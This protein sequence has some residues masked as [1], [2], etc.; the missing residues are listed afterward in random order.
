MRFVMRVF[1]LDC[2]MGA[3][4]PRADRMSRPQL[5]SRVV[6]SLLRNDSHPIDGKSEARLQVQLVRASAEFAIP[7]FLVW[8]KGQP[9]TPKTQKAKVAHSGATAGKLST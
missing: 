6:L 1:F 4:P 2:Y 9:A 3:T 5:V 8:P 7:T